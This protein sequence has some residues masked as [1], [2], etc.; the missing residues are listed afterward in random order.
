MLKNLNS[1][2]RLSVI[3]IAAS[4]LTLVGC[5]DKQ[6]AMQVELDSAKMENQEL[7]NRIDQQ[8]AALDSCDNEK[9]GLQSQVTSLQS[10]PSVGYE[11]GRGNRV[12]G[13][14]GGTTVL[15]VAGD[16]L[17]APGSAT[18]KAD[19]R[20]ELNRIASQLN[21]QYSGHPIRVEGHTDSDPLKKSK[22][23]W[24]SNENLSQAR[25]QAV[26]DYLAGKGV[27]AGRMSV[28]GMGSSKPRGDKKSSRRV[29][30]VVLAMN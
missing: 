2:R 11:T 24:G 29:E 4:C 20:G 9:R 14:G 30:I 1:L 15:T 28:V 6:K 10:A 13:S 21:G 12:G 17:F 19:A 5:N 25:A 27:S 22:A 8:Q 7:R 16:T 26:A 18:I 3:A 23:K